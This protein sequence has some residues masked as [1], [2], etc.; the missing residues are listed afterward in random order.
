[1]SMNIAQDVRIGDQ[2]DLQLN[3]AT[4]MSGI[5]HD[6]DPDNMSLLLGSKKILFQDIVGWTVTSHVMRDVYQTQHQD[7][8]RFAHNTE[9]RMLR[10]IGAYLANNGFTVEQLPDGLPHWSRSEI[11]EYALITSVSKHFIAEE[12]ADL[13][14]KNMLRHGKSTKGKFITFRKRVGVLPVPRGLNKELELIAYV[15][16]Y[17]DEY[18]AD[19]FEV[20]QEVRVKVPQSIQVGDRCYLEIKQG[21][22]VTIMQKL[23][24]DQYFIRTQG[25]QKWSLLASHL[26]RI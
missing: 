10:T 2:V 24:N 19:H 15:L 6:M 17:R 25:N 21:E 22:V 26:E 13:F 1:M 9:Q 20:G 3:N 18:R 16:F 11:M 8:V 5:V 7:D 14:V 23:N 12:F 4:L